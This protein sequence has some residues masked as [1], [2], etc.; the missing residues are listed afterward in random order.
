M[1]DNLEKLKQILYEVTD[2]TGAQSVL[3]WDQQTYMPAGGAEGRG[4]QLSTLAKITHDRF[5]SDEL[6]ELLDLLLPTVDTA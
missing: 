4:E 6:G 1:T 3:G 2:L 5:I